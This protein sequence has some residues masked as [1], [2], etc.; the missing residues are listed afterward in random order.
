MKLYC[1][2][3]WMQWTFN[4]DLFLETKAVISSRINY[5]PTSTETLTVAKKQKFQ[6]GKKHQQ[7]MRIELHA[8][9]VR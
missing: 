1:K 5:W 4:S 2:D 9:N 8:K 6:L 7:K 3:S